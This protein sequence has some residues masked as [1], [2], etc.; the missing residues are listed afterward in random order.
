MVEIA[1][2]VLVLLLL[3][4]WVGV[5]LLFYFCPPL[6]V[7]AVILYFHLHSRLLRKD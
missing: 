4:G 6:G 2:S 7:A 5:A 1:I 3:L